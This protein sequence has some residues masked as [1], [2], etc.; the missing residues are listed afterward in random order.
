VA[1]AIRRLFGR[2]GGWAFALLVAVLIPASVRAGGKGVIEVGLASHYNWGAAD[3]AEFE[4]N[5][6]YGL[7]VHY[8]L[9]DTTSI[10]GGFDQMKFQV[11]FTVNGTDKPY[12]YTANVLYLGCR[13]R[14]KIDFF[15]APYLELGVG[16]QSWNIDQVHTPLELRRG[17]SVMYLVGAGVEYDLLHTVTVSANL[18]YYDMVMREHL[19]TEAHTQLSGKLHADSAP[20]ENVGFTAAGIELTW[21]FR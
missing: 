6:S 8:W 17:S 3:A 21:R 18:R 2:S 7:I 4:P 16:Y 5:I 14:P 10:M 19:D 20:F 9:N 11:P 15:L 12:L 1:K 13:Y